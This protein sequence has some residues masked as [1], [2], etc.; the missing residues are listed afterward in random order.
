MS[1]SQSHG[2]NSRVILKF[3]SSLN[4][5]SV[6]ESQRKGRGCALT[7]GAW[8]AQG[9]SSSSGQSCKQGDVCASF[10]SRSQPLPA[11]SAGHAG[12]LPTL[13]YFGKELRS[14]ITAA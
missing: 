9:S 11:C 1:R 10:C 7:L 4:P 3:L 14:S 13:F 6:Q 2:G 12:N 8:G 5:K